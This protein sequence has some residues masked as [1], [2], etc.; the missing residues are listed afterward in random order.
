MNDMSKLKSETQN[1]NTDNQ[2]LRLTVDGVPVKLN[3][4]PKADGDT[5]VETLKRMILN[6]SAKV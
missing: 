2:Q 5:K 6:G 3:F 1:K 4:S